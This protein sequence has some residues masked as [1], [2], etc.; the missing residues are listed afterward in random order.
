[1]LNV[2]VYSVKAL[3]VRGTLF[4][5]HGLVCVKVNYSLTGGGNGEK[6]QDVKSWVS[7][8]T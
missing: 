7:M 1:M 3:V 2:M 8:E 6:K 5:S 4:L